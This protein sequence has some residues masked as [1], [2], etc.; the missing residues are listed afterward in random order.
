MNGWALVYTSYAGE[1]ERLRE[2]LCTLGNGYFATRGAASHV[3]ADQYHYPGTYVAGCYNRLV[4]RIDGREVQNESMVNL[5]NWLLLG[6]RIDEGP[7][8]NLEAVE[9]LSY[10]QEL[11]MREGELR[12][13]IRFRDEAGRETML[14]ERRLVHMDMS[15][16]A[17]LELSIEPENWSGM[18]EIRSA[19]DGTVSNSGVARYRRLAS[20]HLE[21]LDLG[22]ADD[23]TLRLKVRTTDSR[24][25]IAQAARTRIFRNDCRVP[26]KPTVVIDGGRAEHRFSVEAEVGSCVRVEKHVALYTSRD[27]AIYECGGEAVRLVATMPEFAELSRTQHLVWDQLWRRF[28]LDITHTDEGT[29]D[30]IETVLRLHVFHLLQTTSPNSRD[31]DVG[32]PARG[33]HGEAYRGHVFWDELFVFPTFN[34]R[35]PEITRAVLAY[36]YRRLDEARRMAIAAG[37]RG[38]MYPWQSGSNGREESQ[39]LHLNPRSGRWL[40][41]H[42]HLQRHVSSAIA[43]NV[44]SYHEA[45]GDH[46]FLAF[47]GAEMMLEIARFWSSIC[48]FNKK[49]QRYEIHRVVGPDEYHVAYP[50]TPHS[51]I[52]NNAY[53]NVMAVWVIR[54]A[55]DLAT[56]LPTQRWEE[57]VALLDIDQRELD[58]WKD[59]SRRMFVPFHDN[60][61]HE[62]GRII[63]QFEGYE[64]LKEFD[65]DG[66]R[67][68]YADI[69]RLD[70]LLESEGDSPNNYKASKQADVLML[71]YL[72]SAEELTDIFDQ[73]GYPFDPESIPENVAYY[74]DRTSDGSSLS[75][76]VHSW[77][78]ARSNRD[79]A[80]T[81]FTDALES[82]LVDVQ[83]GTTEEGIHVGAMAGT[84]DLIQRCFTGIETRDGVL[85]LNPRLP[86][87]L[88]CLRLQ[89]HYQGHVIDLEV[90]N[91]ILEVR[92]G[93]DSGRTLKVGVAGTIEQI[94]PGTLR[95]FNLQ[96]S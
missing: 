22:A 48:Q 61:S 38:A 66:Y 59:I 17:A 34:L 24:I 90:T 32:I 95:R 96:P 63:S 20:R 93:A 39:R 83:G 58:L 11:A 71:F 9:V 60:G 18:L 3:S 10:R 78:L 49:R 94:E 76:V 53:T 12:R 65:W 15:H 85:W 84:V 75:K 88:K 19:L 5:P 51:G 40:E 52:N 77:V 87:P 43:Y 46:E 91:S 82:D 55:L 64:S 45:T 67:A 30:H 92:A 14:N 44:W 62:T 57:L 2:A 29:D 54:R 81:V 25:E 41:D 73:L 86:S 72:L 36:R 79:S 27:N 16:C 28:A 23:E 68:A 42:T 89:L 7:W 50:D 70:R 74:L 31:L 47:Y 26:V 37:Y 35:L 69:Q 80:W 1:Q 33:L 8:F 13:S 56:V 6:F 4:D 21:V